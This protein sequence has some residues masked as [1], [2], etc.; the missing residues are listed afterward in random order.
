MIPE[1]FRLSIANGQ[2]QAAIL[3][4]DAERYADHLEDVLVGSVR[5]GSQKRFDEALGIF[6]EEMPASWLL[7]DRIR[8]LA[9]QYG[10]KRE[11]EKS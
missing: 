10:L 5:I 1:R 6:Q 7:V 3:D 4:N 11:K 8:Q 2:S 9:E